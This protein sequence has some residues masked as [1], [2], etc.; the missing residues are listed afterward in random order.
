MEENEV[1]TQGDEKSKKK[2]EGEGVDIMTE[3]ASV[4]L[5]KC[6]ET[7]LS[8]RLA[9]FISFGCAFLHFFR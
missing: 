3:G 8:A 6:F 4:F 2:E 7:S 5:G 9:S 1:M